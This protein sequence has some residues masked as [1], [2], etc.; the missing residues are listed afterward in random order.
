MRLVVSSGSRNWGGLERVA[1]QLAGGLADRGHEVVVFC[2]RGSP[3]HER[4]RPRF[5][6]EPV[7]RGERLDPTTV[8][9]C[10]L[11]LRRHRPDA[12]IGNTPKDPGWTGLAARLLGIP[13][14][15]RHELN[16]P[17][18]GGPLGRLVFGRVPTV[19][20]VN[21]ASTRGTV[22]GSAPWLPPERVRVIPNGVDPEEP[23]AAA[24]D[25]GLPAGALVFG[26]VGRWEEQK[27]IRE[28]LQAWPRV[29]AEVPSA[30]LALVGW[31]AEGERLRAGLREVPHLHWLGF[32]DDVPALMRRFDVLVAP[33]HREGFGLVLVEAMAVGTPVIA[34]DST[35]LPEIVTDRV[36]GRLVA[37]GDA[38]A[39]G[40]AMVELARDPE[41]RRRMGEAGRDRILREFTLDRMLDAHEALLAEVAR[42]G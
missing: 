8:A 42:R 37:V 3:L 38:E 17:Y 14:V 5:A 10:L 13:V 12:V 21:S 31:G 23:G 20:V 39:L 11:A 7:L 16:R 33:F 2:R 27:G 22:L 28:L 24:A 9:R 32:R 25:L 1:Q 6:C 34:A 30:H 35:S 41:A 19:H 15:Y 40:A 4:L 26:F 18:P 29:V 36:E